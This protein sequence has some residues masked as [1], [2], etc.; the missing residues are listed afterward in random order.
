MSIQIRLVADELSP[1]LA[2]LR[3]AT[4]NLRPALEAG[5]LAIVSLAQRAFTDASLRQSPWAPKRNGSPARLIESGTLIRSIRI[6]GVTDRTVTVGTDR[7]YAAIHQ[8]GGT[9]V[10]KAGKKFL[11]FQVG[12]KKV[13]AR[14]VK[15]PARPFFPVT[16]AGQVTSAAQTRVLAAVQAALGLGGTAGA[17]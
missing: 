17:A 6:T 16:A 8:F 13:F 15:I 14:Q 9:I 10:P 5:G 2:A 12:G 1:R 11:V 3:G 7:V 4:A